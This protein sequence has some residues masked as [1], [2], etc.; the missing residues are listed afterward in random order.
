MSELLST[1]DPE[2]V[3]VPY[4]HA[5]IDGLAN[6]GGLYVA[7]NMPAISEEELRGFTGLHYAELAAAI[8][9]RFVSEDEIPHK[10]ILRMMHTAYSLDRFPH[11]ID[12][13][14]TPLRRVSNTDIYIQNLSL[15]PTGAFKDIPMQPLGQ[16]FQ[17]L[18]GALNRH[19]RILAATSGDTGPSAMAAL[20]NLERLSIAV[21]SPYEGMS[22]F[23]WAQAGIL[24][25]GNVV[26][27]S[28]MAPFD[29]L[30]DLVKKMSQQEEFADL[31]A[32]NS[33]NWSRV[34][35]QIPYYFAAYLQA[36][37]Q[38]GLQFGDEVDVVVPSGNFGNVLAGYYAKQMGL[39]IRKLIIATNE[40]NVLDEMVQTGVYR[41]TG[42][43]ITSSP[44]MDIAKASNLE[45]VIYEIFD[46]DPLT[47][48]R[49]MKE[50]ESSGTVAFATYGIPSDIMKTLGFE[51]DSSSHTER[52]QTIKWM[53]LNSNRDVI[54][55]HTADAVTVARRLPQDGVPKICMETAL[56]VKFEDTIRQAIGFV[57]P[58]TDRRFVGIEDRVPDGAFTILDDVSVN[59]L[60]RILREKLPKA[61]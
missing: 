45:R 15:G 42:S 8:K 54:D 2:E 32:V 13:V 16:E 4:T 61:A 53:Y 10:D 33:I 17:Y 1:R 60:A 29:P 11:T 21:L 12:G 30:Q 48:A 38:A 44:S 50:F 18:L 3:R 28:G 6:H 52:L 58:R 55:P 9:S 34:T 39:P 26:N 31:G 41:N 24:S 59:G 23:Q 35:S 49:F 20:K 40:N 56:A 37:E 7:T 25:G 19:L 5:V 14:V 51:S 43:T 57:P 22:K 47:T 27:I 46:R 36:I